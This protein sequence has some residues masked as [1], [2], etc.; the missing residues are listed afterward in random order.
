[1]KL[2]KYIRD[3]QDF[4]TPGIIFKDITPL[5]G[6]RT[7]FAKACQELVALVGD[8]QI[9]KVV[10][11][12][13]RGFFFGGVLAE[14]LN[15]GF[16]PVRKPGKLP[17]KTA[18]QSYALEYGTDTLEIHEDAIQPGDKVLVHDDVLATGGTAAAVV[19]LI[20]ALGGEVV[21]CNFLIELSFLS[22]R[23]KL[24]GHA[25]AAAITY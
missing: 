3:I 10:G 9:D 5:L 7:A 19:K 14:K 17:Y 16:V 25:I 23:E 8:Q 22:G 6:D 18:S 15:V 11:V 21:Q 12:E 2:I 24:Q 4:P 1:M 20:E 13:S